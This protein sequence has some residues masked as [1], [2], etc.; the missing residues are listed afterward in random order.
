MLCHCDRPHF[1]PTYNSRKNCILVYFN[2]CSKLRLLK[3]QLKGLNITEVCESQISHSW[4]SWTLRHGSSNQT[5]WFHYDIDWVNG[6]TLHLPLCTKLMNT[7]AAY[8]KTSSKISRHMTWLQQVKN[9]QSGDAINPLNA[10]LNPICH[11][12][13]LLGGATIVVVSRLR[14]NWVRRYAYLSITVSK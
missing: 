12:L 13:A 5:P 9:S 4:Y 1:T 6:Y 11:L 14:V 10:E 2:L 7:S 8:P 3:W